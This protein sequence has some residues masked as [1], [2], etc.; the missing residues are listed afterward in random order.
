MLI[1]GEIRLFTHSQLLNHT[2]DLQQ[3]TQGGSDI[4]GLLVLF[5]SWLTTMAASLSVCKAQPLC[6][7]NELQFRDGT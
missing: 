6:Y 1:Y 7:H 2:E 3:S 5:I 4:H